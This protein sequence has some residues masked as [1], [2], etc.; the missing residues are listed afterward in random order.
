MRNTEVAPESMPADPH[1]LASSSDQRWRLVDGVMRRHGYRADAL[2]ETLHVVQR[3][4]GHLDRESLRVVAG[5][6]QVPLSRAYG[7]ATFYHLFTLRPPARHT[8]I[9]CVG[10]AC[11]IN[12]APALVTV[13]QEALGIELG[14]GR[15]DGEVSLAPAHC[16]GCCSVAPAGLIDGALAGKLTPEDLRMRLLNWSGD[17]A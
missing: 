10:T 12:G 4:F 11:H 16:F 15:D 9:V 1:T 3:A 17:D 13:A 6:L 7:V 2:I 5:E 14:E 8:C